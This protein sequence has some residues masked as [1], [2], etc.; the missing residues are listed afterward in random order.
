MAK[1]RLVYVVCEE[2]ITRARIP[3][4]DYDEALQEPGVFATFGEA[5]REAVEQVQISIASQLRRMQ[6]LRSL[7]A[8]D[9]E[10]TWTENVGSLLGY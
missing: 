9:T 6:G 8:R 2:E 1:T 4:T 7:R 3:A 5:K 10:E